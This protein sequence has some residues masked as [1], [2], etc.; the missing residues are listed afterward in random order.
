MAASTLLPLQGDYRGKGL[1]EV[2]QPYRGDVECV[3]GAQFVKHSLELE[4]SLRAG[5]LCPDPESFPESAV[6][7]PELRQL[8]HSLATCRGNESSLLVYVG[9]GV[10]IKSG[11]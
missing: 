7:L 9:S 3:Q 11:L 6:V 10:E 1:V 2:L 4:A 8:A 5:K